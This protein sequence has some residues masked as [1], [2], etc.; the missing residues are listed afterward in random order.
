MAY[1]G[2]LKYSVAFYALDG[3]GTAN[4]EP[5]VLIKGGSPRKQVIYVDVPAPENG[6]K[7]NEEILMMEVRLKFWL[8][9]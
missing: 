5:Q 3:L 9:M 2:K 4:F 6:L 1:G 7:Q 8:Y